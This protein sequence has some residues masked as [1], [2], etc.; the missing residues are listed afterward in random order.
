MEL[1]DMFLMTKVKKLIN[2]IPNLDFYNMCNNHCK[3]RDSSDSVPMLKIDIR[4]STWDITED[5]ENYRFYLASEKIYHYVWHEFADKIIEETKDKL[6][7]SETQLMLID[8]LYL[9]R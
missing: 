8:I 2:E 9:R 3:S 1:K 5:M 4:S 7:D 6:D